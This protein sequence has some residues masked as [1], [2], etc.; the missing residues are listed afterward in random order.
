MSNGYLSEEPLRFGCGGRMFGILTLPAK[1]ACVERNLPVFVFLSAGLLHRVGPF[2]LHVRLARE[3][4]RMG[5]TSLRVD[6]AGTGDSP[7]RFGFTSQ[8]SV[9]ADFDEI[10]TVLDARLRSFSLILAGLC[11]GADNAT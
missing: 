6:L 3:L 7:T 5:F 4:A 1:I 10:L 9:F 2:R 11:S 8:Q